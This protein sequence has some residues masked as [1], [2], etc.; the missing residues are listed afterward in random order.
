MSIGH[1]RCPN[2]ACPNRLVKLQKHPFHYLAAT[3]LPTQPE[4]TS[5][6]SIIP[7]GLHVELLPLVH[8]GFSA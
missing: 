2:L 3:P 4:V 5:S 1:D 6:S 8:V 7:D